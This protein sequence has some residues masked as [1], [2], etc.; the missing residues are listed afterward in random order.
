MPDNNIYKKLQKLQG[1]KKPEPDIDLD[2]LIENVKAPTGG[3]FL[4]WQPVEGQQEEAAMDIPNYT[5][6]IINDS[7]HPD[8][9]MAVVGEDGIVTAYLPE[10]VVVLDINYLELHKH[11]VDGQT[12]FQAFQI[13]NVN[14]VPT[15]QRTCKWFNPSRDYAETFGAIDSEF[16][17]Y[18]RPFR[19]GTCSN[20]EMIKESGTNAPICPW[21]ANGDVFTKCSVYSPEPQR[22]RQALYNQDTKGY[23]KLLQTRRAFGLSE[24]QIVQESED[25]SSEV[26]HTILV[27]NTTTDWTQVLDEAWDNKRLEYGFDDD[28][29]VVDVTYKFLPETPAKDP[30]F[31]HVLQIQS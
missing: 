30:Y 25:Q 24:Y 8:V 23:L 3:A 19:N 5:V 15:G 16:Y 28:D 29:K 4:P 7:D 6:N 18:D 10:G 26:L 17:E 12:R 1:A 31:N 11:I 13:L 14:V 27:D 2:A 22:V 20:P 21:A 9:K